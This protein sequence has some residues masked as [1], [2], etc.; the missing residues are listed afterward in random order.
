MA[1]VQSVKSLMEAG[2]LCN[3]CGVVATSA[4]AAQ[5]E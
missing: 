5:T 2:A 1:S 4:N 3:A